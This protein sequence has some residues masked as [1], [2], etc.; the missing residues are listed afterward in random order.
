MLAH[1]HRLATWLDA[2]PLYQLYQ[3]PSN[4][5]FLTA[6]NLDFE[7]YAQQYRK[8]LPKNDLYIY[9]QGETMIGSY[10][11]TRKAYPLQHILTLSRFVIATQYQG[12]G[13]GQRM[14]EEAILRAKPVIRIELLVETDNPKAITLYQKCGFCIEGRLK[15]FFYRPT[16]DEYVDEFLMA[17]VF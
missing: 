3:E 12:Q 1:R 15:K 5:P 2:R 16:T 10:R 6:A 14:L 8:I 7:T 4:Y 9:Q 11:L 13:H 17:L